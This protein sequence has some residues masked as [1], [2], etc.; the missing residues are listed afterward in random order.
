MRVIGINAVYGI[1]STGRTVKQLDEGLKKYGV[2]STT[3][4]FA[5]PGTERDCRINTANGVKLHSLMARL[6]GNSG[7]YSAGATKKLLKY[8]DEQRP[9]I[10]HLHNLHSNFID[11]PMLFEYLSAKSIPTAVTLHDC[12]WYT[13]KCTHYTIDGC[14]KWLSCCGGCP[15]LKKDIPSWFFDR[16]GKLLEDKKK[17]FASVKP[18]A[19]IGV[20]DWIT[21]EAK[22]SFLGKADIIERI[23]NWIDTD[24]FKPTVSNI[25]QKY[26]VEDKRLLLGVASQWSESK[27]LNDFR[28]LSKSLPSDMCI[29]L[30][31]RC[32]QADVIDSPNVIMIPATDSQKTLAEWY[33]AA[34][35]FLTLS[36]EE[37]FGKVSAEALA[38]GTPVLAVD[39]TANPELVGE[40]C[41]CSIDDTSPSA[42]LEGVNRILS[43]G[44][45]HYADACRSF[46]LANFDMERLIAQTADVYNGL[47]SIGVGGNEAC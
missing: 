22:K 37:S 3:V 8:L 31:G 26:G 47:L 43:F 42:V 2:D 32:D 1:A 38:C 16:T 7:Y 34:D 21:G 29:V 41:G 36:K 17:W 39:S 35:V 12:W 19:V 4:Y 30:I 13:G 11:L 33:S 28:E 45:Q 14:R 18:L 20:S 40:N 6:F 25:R 24:A 44:K 10:V 46:A 15:R 27:G 23:Y 9:D 5:G